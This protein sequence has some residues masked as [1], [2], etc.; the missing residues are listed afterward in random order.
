[1]H[2]LV[3]CVFNAFSL[4]NDYG[5]S[6][7]CRA[8]MVYAVWSTFAYLVNLLLAS[9]FVSTSP[10]V[11]MV[12][13]ALALGIYSACCALNWSWQVWF[14]LGLVR[15][16]YFQVGAYCLLM[17][18]LVWDDYILMRWLWGNVQKKYRARNHKNGKDL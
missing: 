16:K 6:N 9:R 18:M 13:S 17:S 15:I 1:M 7:V 2:H 4:Y 11:S 3:V 5:E 8:I 10:L 12:L 14:L